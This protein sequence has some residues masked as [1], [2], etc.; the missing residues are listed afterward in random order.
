MPSSCLALLLSVLSG[1]TMP[2]SPLTIRL[3]LPPAAPDLC[4]QYAQ[5]V[6]LCASQLLVA[7]HAHGLAVR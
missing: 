7:L 6:P 5:D 4:V 2:F 1:C 3:S